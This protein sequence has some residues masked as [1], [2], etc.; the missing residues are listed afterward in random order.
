MT[1]GKLELNAR[2]VTDPSD[3]RAVMIT[4]PLGGDF[5]LARV[6]VSQRQAVVCFPKFMTIGIGFRR[7][8]DWNTNLPYTCEAAEIFAHIRHNKGR[9]ASDED[10]LTAIRKLQDFA[11]GLMATRKATT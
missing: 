9:R 5:W 3:G 10:C 7:E 8:Q 2:E 11:A 1:L 4:P 6:R